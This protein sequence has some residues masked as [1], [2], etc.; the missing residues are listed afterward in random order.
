MR[1]WTQTTF[2]TSFPSSNHACRGHMGADVSSPNASKS[3]EAGLRASR[4]RR[5]SP[6]A[7]A[8]AG[9]SFP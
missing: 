4:V 6:A 2:E 9:K 8:G 5:G 7:A 3:D 1:L